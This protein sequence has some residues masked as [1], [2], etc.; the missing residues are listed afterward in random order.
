MLDQ[1]LDVPQRQPPQS[2][3]CGRRQAVAATTTVDRG[4]RTGEITALLQRHHD[5]DR[6]A[7]DDLLSLVYDHLRHVARSQLA[8]GW[9]SSTFTPTALVHEV[10]IQLADETGVAWQ[11]RSHFFAICA[12]AMRRVLVDHARHHGAQKRTGGRR[13]LVLDDVDLGVDAQAELIVAV[14]EALTSLA[15]L[16]PRFSRVVECRYFAGLTEDE[17]AAA[18]DTSVRT[19]QR[20]WMRARAWLLKALG[21]VPPDRQ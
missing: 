17:T 6:Q 12:R 14:D 9:P 15:R 3:T 7:Y 10:Y 20:D 11:D 19:V 18:L 8:R 5:G 13:R 4:D 1:P 2:S 16:N 21:A